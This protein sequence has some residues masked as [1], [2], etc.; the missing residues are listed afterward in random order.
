MDEIQ[1]MVLVFTVAIACL[2]VL[3]ISFWLIMHQDSTV[4][5]TVSATVGG[6]IGYLYKLLKDKMKSR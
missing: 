3:A 2:T 1:A 4:L 5:T 6:I